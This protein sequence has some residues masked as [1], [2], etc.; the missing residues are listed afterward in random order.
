[1]FK[2]WAGRAALA[3]AVTAG[4]FWGSALFVGPNIPA[5]V[6]HGGMSAAALDTF[7]KLTNALNVAVWPNFASDPYTCDSS[8][9]GGY[10]YNTGSNAFQVCDGTSWAA[11][12]GGVAVLND[13]TDVFISAPAD[14]EVVKYDGVTDNRWENQAQSA[15]AIDDLSDVTITAPS[16]G[17]TLEWS[18]T[19]W[20]NVATGTSSFA[21][22]SDTAITTPARMESLIFD[23]TDWI[24]VNSESSFVLF[25]QMHV[26]AGTTVEQQIISVADQVKVFRYSFPHGIEVDRVV[27]G[28]A[29]VSATGCLN[30]AVGIYTLDGN[31]LLVNSGA[32]LYDTNDEIHNVDIGNVFVDP[33]DYWIAYTADDA[34]GSCDA[35]ALTDL[36]STPDVDLIMNT[37]NT[38]VGN[39]ANPSAAGVLPATLGTITANE[40]VNRP[41]IKFVGID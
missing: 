39:A 15:S 14:G 21:G 19:L 38:L 40:N 27:W 8:S 7:G 41:I 37:G 36:N 6:A 5:I 11:G 25:P 13:L 16:S 28:V 29:I 4:A 3:G 20:A 18:G 17:Q 22:L 12:G 10:Y 1:M 9:T 23:G 2:R 24:N 32:Q 31:T 26:A 33:G 35:I 30:G 34:T